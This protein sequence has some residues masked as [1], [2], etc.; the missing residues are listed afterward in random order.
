MILET[1]K[2][3][4]TCSS[5]DKKIKTRITSN[6]FQNFNFMYASWVGPGLP[7]LFSRTAPIDHCMHTFVQRQHFSVFTQKNK[8]YMDDVLIL[9]FFLL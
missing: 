2:L 8:V 1:G 7:C 3:Y 4:V 5:N 9:R 6:N